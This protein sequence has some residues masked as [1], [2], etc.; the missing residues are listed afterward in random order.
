MAFLGYARLPGPCSRHLPSVSQL[1]ASLS[2]RAAAVP[3]LG[4]GLP[5]WIS[6]L[7]PHVQQCPHHLCNPGPTLNKRQQSP[8]A[9]RTKTKLVRMASG[10]WP[11]SQHLSGPL[12][13]SCSHRDLISQFL[14]CASLVCLGGLHMLIP[15][16]NAPF[17]PP[18]H[19]TFRF[20]CSTTSSKMHSLT[21]IPA[22]NRSQEAHCPAGPC[23][24]S[25]CVWVHV[26]VCVCM[27][28][29]T[30]THLAL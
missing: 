6:C 29:C 18:D 11:P 5:L 12:S 9:F 16:L 26:H 24:L 13:S 14:N 1:P 23:C 19:F 21:T 2:P 20:Q 15:L 4:Q 3:G 25:H 10:P 27:H 28:A 7:A 22:T 8:L 30:H 17:H